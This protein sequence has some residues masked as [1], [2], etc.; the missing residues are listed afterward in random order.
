MMKERVMTTSSFPLSAL[1]VVVA[2]CRSVVFADT[3]DLSV[4]DF[5]STLKFGLAWRRTTATK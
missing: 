1:V 3:R 4:F 5:F 2:L